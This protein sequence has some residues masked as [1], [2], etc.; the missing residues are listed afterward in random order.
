MRKSD[1]ILSADFFAIK[2]AKQ[3][4]QKGGCN[5]DTWDDYIQAARMGLVNAAQTYD[6]D[7]G[8]FTTW[9]HWHIKK[10]LID[11]QKKYMPVHVPSRAYA[12]MSK[13]ERNNCY[14]CGVSLN[15]PVKATDGETTLEDIIPDPSHPLIQSDEEKRKMAR[16]L[17][18][19]AMHSANL[20][21]RDVDVLIN[22][23]GL[24]GNT[25]KTQ[26]EVA[27]EYG[28]TK[29]RIGQI[30]TAAHDKLRRAVLRAVGDRAN[31]LAF[32]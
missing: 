26:I 11:L 29:Q 18:T 30:L 4:W 9:A 31:L 8:A 19:K 2:E 28:L 7:Q 24:A 12:N 3:A 16:D 13:E 25:P 14:R 17:I 22:V 20:S 6:S 27:N 21:Q 32:L 15:A 1:L 5:P 10:Q 23:Y